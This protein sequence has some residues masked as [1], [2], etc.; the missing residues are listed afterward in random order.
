MKINI[1]KGRYWDEGIKLV[2]G[3][4]RVSPGC[5][6]CWSLVMENRFNK[7]RCAVEC[8]PDRLKRFN[9]RKPKVFAIWNDL[10]WEE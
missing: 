3:C 4:T 2:S 8:H 6:N 10:F 9:T 1:E 7:A 5:K